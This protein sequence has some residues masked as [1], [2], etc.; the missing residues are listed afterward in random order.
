M[1][2]IRTVSGSSAP[3]PSDRPPSVTGTA[4]SGPIRSRAPPALLPTFCDPDRWSCS[5]TNCSGSLRWAM[6]CRRL[7][8]QNSRRTTVMRSPMDTTEPAMAAV[9]ALFL[10]ESRVRWWMG[11]YTEGRYLGD[12]D[13]TVGIEGASVDDEE[14]LMVIDGAGS[15]T[16]SVTSAEL[17][18]LDGKE[19]L[20]VTDGVGVTG[21]VGRICSERRD[22][23]CIEVAMELRVVRLQQADGLTVGRSN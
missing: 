5:L 16:G 4:F 14:L 20:M 9:H 12:F 6:R 13:D 22:F 23:A 7:R 15:S 8:T 18:E 10:W 21:N 11:W 3:A 1:R 19:S 17:A 2:R